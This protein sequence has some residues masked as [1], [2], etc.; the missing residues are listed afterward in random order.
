M[1]TDD[2]DNVLTGVTA[3]FLGTNA[4]AANVACT[5]T[6][7]FVV[8]AQDGAQ[9]DFSGAVARSCRWCNGAADEVWGMTGLT[10]PVTADRKITGISWWSSDTNSVSHLHRKAW[11]T[12]TKM[13][14]MD[15]AASGCKGASAPTVIR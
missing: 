9:N 4:T 2:V 5:G 11:L 13:I 6:F 1:C 10:P 15:V 3:V 7:S 8:G 14:G 12:K